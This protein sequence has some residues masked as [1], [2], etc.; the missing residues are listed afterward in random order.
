MAVTEA[1]SH[2]STRRGPGGPGHHALPA[3]TACLTVLAA[4][5]VV[6][7]G[8]AS[9]RSAQPTHHRPPSR[10]VFAV[11]AAAVDVT[12]PAAGPGVANPAAACATP[13]QL[14]QHDGHHL[15]SLEEPYTDV[16]HN[17][18][19]DVGEPFVDCPTPL[20]NGGTAPPDGR[21]DGIYARRWRLLRPASPPRCSTPVGAHRRGP[22]RRPHG[23]AHER[24][25][26]GRVQG[27]LGPGAGQGPRRRVPV[28]RHH[29]LHVDPRRVGAR[30]DRHHRPQRVHV[31]RRRLL[32]AVPGRR[33]GAQH[34]AGGDAA[35]G[36][37]SSA[38]GRCTPTTSC[39]AGRR[40]RSRRRGRSA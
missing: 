5:T 28:G 23:V 37:P 16:N 40:T 20:V 15:L 29:A 9:A 25:Q 22:Q 36:P 4:L 31:R 6:T 18:I 39:P 17:G 21:W 32:R 26:R 34:R 30:H 14:A 2:R 3:V 27:D 12:P 13:L 38:T 10:A 24:R 8:P 11:G 19:W 1:R 33:R 7:T 35:H